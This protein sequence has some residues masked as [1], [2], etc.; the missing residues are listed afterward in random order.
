M[1]DIDESCFAKPVEPDVSVY[2]HKKARAMGIPASG[3][4]ELTS[5]CNFNC[6]MCYIH[7]SDCREAQKDELTA[8]QWL[9]IGKEAAD[10]GVIFLLLTGGEPLIRKDFEEIY[11][12]LKKLGFYISINT[13]GSLLTD[14]IFELF[15][16]DPPARLNITLYGA[17]NETYGKLCGGEY[18]DTVMKNIKRAVDM[19]LQVKLN[20]SITPYNCGDIEAIY[21]IAEENGLHVKSSPYMYPPMRKDETSMGENSGRFTSEDAAYYRVLDEYTHYG[22]EHFIKKAES[23]LKSLEFPLPQNVDE[24]EKI[25]CRAGTSSFWID[26][27]G[28]MGACGMIPVE[29]NSVVEKGFNDCWEKVKSETDTIR[30]P[31]KCSVCRYKHICNVCPAVCYTETGTFGT[32]PDYVCSYT[33]K[34]VDFIKTRLTEESL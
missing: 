2:L 18:F 27:K 25:K 29:N 32:A 13:N 8:E 19:G 20:F 7:N 30:M 5:R 15:K 6:K 23:F 22:R 21:K 11:K 9:K 14:R 10:K 26:W 17:G 16:N 31:K 4:F 34:T 33:E 24:G 1:S 28:N 3:N 12:G